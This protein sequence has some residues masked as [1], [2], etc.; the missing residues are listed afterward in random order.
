MALA[1]FLCFLEFVDFCNLASHSSLRSFTILTQRGKGTLHFQLGG[2]PMQI[3][4]RWF[5]LA[6]KRGGGV[7]GSVKETLHKD[8]KTQPPGKPLLLCALQAMPR[9]HLGGICEARQHR[10][11]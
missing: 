4:A 7:A 1:A 3:C 10:D 6:Q 9:V 8:Q 5:H 2:V 11:P